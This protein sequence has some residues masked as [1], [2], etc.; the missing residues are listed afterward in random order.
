MSLFTIINRKKKSQAH[1]ENR[2]N[3]S[4]TNLSQ[5]LGNAEYCIVFLSSA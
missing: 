1:N 5:S 4:T 3:K 2:N